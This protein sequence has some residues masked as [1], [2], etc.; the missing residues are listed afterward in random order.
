[1]HRHPLLT[2]DS[3]GLEKS[4][5]PRSLLIFARKP[6]E[7]DRSPYELDQVD[8]SQVKSLSDS[9]GLSIQ[10]RSGIIDVSK[11]GRSIQFTPLKD[12]EVESKN[13]DSLRS[14]ILFKNFY[15]RR[16]FIRYRNRVK[17]SVFERNRLVVSR[18][19]LSC[20]YP[21]QSG[22]E[23]ICGK[24][25]MIANYEI[26][27]LP[28][29]S[30]TQWDCLIQSLD[31]DVSCFSVAVESLSSQVH[32]CMSDVLRSLNSDCLRE[33][34]DLGR[35]SISKKREMERATA[36]KQR[37]LKQS[38]T[39]V[40]Y[41]KKLITLRIRDCFQDSLDSSV[42]SLERILTGLVIQVVSR[43]DE[44]GELVWIE[45]DDIRAALSKRVSMVEQ[46]LFEA[47]KQLAGDDSFQPFSLGKIS[48]DLDRLVHACS[49][50]LNGL[51]SEALTPLV[52]A[53]SSLMTVYGC[54]ASFDAI[55][56][57]V[58]SLSEVG[59]N[60]AEIPEHL[61]SGIFVLDNTVVISQVRTQMEKAISD[62]KSSAVLSIRSHLRATQAQLDLLSKD[63]A[64]TVSNIEE[65]VIGRRVLV[66][67]ESTTLPNI[68]ALI[69]SLNNS[70]TDLAQHAT[71]LSNEDTYV[72]E[73][74]IGRAQRI[75]NHE[76]SRFRSVV[77]DFAGR[78]DQ[79][80]AGMINEYNKARSIIEEQIA[81]VLRMDPL[82][83][84]S[85]D[86]L[87]TEINAQS[88]AFATLVRLGMGIGLDKIVVPDSSVHETQ[89]EALESDFEILRDLI[90][91]QSNLKSCLLYT[92]PSPR[93]RQKSRM[94]SSA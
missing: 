46:L 13:Y 50:D 81:N 62:L 42:R 26:F 31:H 43:I 72:L 34:N 79:L 73:N 63:L 24:L 23:T 68:Q 66:D 36:E 22:L 65:Y 2:T 30:S 12:W 75:T 37:Q 15:I 19:V 25:S 83:F 58:I 74:I 35:I 89:V 61:C 40:P 17:R 10:T 8:A 92:S 45:S 1:M 32:M 6:N 20:R 44:C 77:V 70:V 88:T 94:P 87:H 59:A 49:R 21:F 53:H 67:T 64:A 9:R 56:R 52:L 28:N 18:R 82:E 4:G 16:G 47:Q 5:L 39:L 76:L 51:K 60:I 90:E 57:R 71:R 29:V 41:F 93:D 84:P 78:A 54:D 80:Y 27:R 14:I 86:H 85:L 48:L 3:Q 55:T 69:E 38:A 11:N 33:D 91:K 7:T